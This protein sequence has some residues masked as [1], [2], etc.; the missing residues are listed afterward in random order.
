MGKKQ[1]D[2]LQRAKE[3]YAD[4]RDLWQDNRRRMLDDLRFSNPVEPEQWD[5]DAL[6]TRKGRPCLTLD[7]TNQ[8]IVQVINTARMN[9]PGINCMPADSRADVDVAEALDGIIRHIEYRSRASIAYDWAMEGAARCGVGWLR[10]VPRVVDPRSNLQEICIDRVADHLSCM[11]DGDQPDGSDAM[12]GFA[13]TLIPK[14]RFKKLY[15]KAST[16]SWDGDAEGWIVGDMVRVCEHQYVEEDEAPMLAVQT[17]DTGEELHLTA[18]EYKE[19]SARIGYQPPAREYKAKTRTVKWCT[20]NGSEILEETIFPGDFIGMV[21]VLGYESF[22]EGKRYICGV[23]RRLMESQKAYNYER[24]ALVEAV[25]LQPKAPLG[26]AA[27]A[28]EG[29]E[30]HYENLNTGQ[31]AYLPFNAFDGEGRPL[32]AP[33][34]MAP[35]AFPVAFAQGSQMAVGDMEA[36]IGMTQAVLGMDNQASS[37]R[38]ERERRQQGQVATFHFVDNLSRSIEHL[39]RIVVGM[40]PSIYDTARQAKILGFDGQQGEVSVDPNMEQASI[41]K[42]RKVVAINPTVGRYDVRVKTGPGYTTQRQ[43]AAE[44]MRDALQAAGPAVAPV[45]LPAMVK[46]QDWPDAERISRALLAVS[47]PEIRAA[48]GDDEEEAPQLPPEAMQ[49]MQQMQQQLQQFTQMLDAAEQEIQRLTAEA[50]S[51]EADRQAK[52]QEAQIAAAGRVRETEITA[53]AGV[54]EAAIKAQGEAA[55]AQITQPQAIEQPEQPDPLAALMPVL[56]SMQ[57]QLAALS[58]GSGLEVVA[59]EHVR[60]PVTGLTAMSKPIYGRPTMQ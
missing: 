11:V 34:R 57:Q 6:T 18:E 33:Q 26:A 29:H 41:R 19:L 22:I 23:T 12:N 24:S 46:M 25:A 7:R 1:Q 59:V 58:S 16:H 9:K 42:G 49:Q 45:L 27:E 43:E 51:K 13:E 55:V 38:Q 53:Q 32:P 10:V 14:K 17:P 56:A 3:C 4:V 48:L 2:Q 44:G 21:P 15:P 20:F 60:D 28:I 35:P 40:I 8:Y 52:L 39:G 31:P 54:Q 50:Q 37:G 30:A 47:P 5:A 36:A